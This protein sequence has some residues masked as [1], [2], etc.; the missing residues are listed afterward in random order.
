LRLR[1]IFIA[2]L[3]AVASLSC[4]A[5]APAL[6]ED[7]PRVEPLPDCFLEIPAEI[8]LKNG[9]DC[10]HVV[11]RQSRNGDGAGEVRLGYMRLNSVGGSNDAPLF[12]L[13]GGPGR[14]MTGDPGVLLLFQAALLGPVLETRDV[15]LVEQRGTLRDLPHLDCP[16][17]WSVQRAAAARGLDDTAGLALLK[18]QIGN[19]VARHAEAGVDLAAY[20]NLENAADVNDVRE[21]LG[22]EQIV[23][24]GASYGTELGQHVMRDFPGTLEA[25]VLDGAGALSVT[26]WSAGQARNAQWGI[27]NLT[28]LCAEDADCAASYDIPAL[29]DAALA[30]L[31]EG[32][33][34]TTVTSPDDPAI[35]FELKITAEAFAGYLH[36]LQTSKYGVMA[37]PAL[38]NAYVAEGRTRVEADMAAQLG[39]E[40]LV[41]P[42]AQDADTAILM[43]LAMICTD[44]PPMSIEEVVTEGAG[45]YAVLFA[46]NSARLYV[47]MCGVLDLPVLPDRADIPVSAEMPVLVLSGGLDVQ[48]PYFIGRGVA[49][50]LPNATHVVFPAGFH[51]QVMNINPCAIRI[52]RDF[53]TDPAVPLD[54]TCV[55]E[56][57]PLP[58]LR[59][60]FSSPEP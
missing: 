10:G 37:F 39:A 29:L 42:A 15:V 46:R 52:A 4:L 3:A 49:D 56:E 27:D 54:T 2:N 45:R 41:D 26:S 12:M 8:A 36:S 21:A 53:I 40:I 9:A 14:A 55:A 57:R 5:A 18:E 20:N 58:F 51:V 23:L 35:S 50:H 22:Y 25:V 60:D 59:P 11:V 32:P 48:T 6:A 16:D 19:C 33:I 24:Y 7:L 47:E 17:F 1:G 13:A 43:H 34:A 30:L 28:R 44:D 38:L 31:D